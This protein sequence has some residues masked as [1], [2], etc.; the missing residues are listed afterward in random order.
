MVSRRKFGYHSG[1]M[2]ALNIQSGTFDITTD[3]SGDG[4]ASV[5]FKYPMDAAPVVVLTAQETLDT[6]VFSVTGKTNQG[7]VGILDG[8]DVTG[9][10]VTVGYIAHLM[11]Q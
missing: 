5:T 9:S 3:G 1:N 6:G 11:R 2:A 7:F 10:A 4:S 8:C